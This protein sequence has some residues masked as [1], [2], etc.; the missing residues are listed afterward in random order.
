MESVEDAADNKMSYMILMR[1]GERM[2]DPGRKG[3]G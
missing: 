3:S 2:D 1:H